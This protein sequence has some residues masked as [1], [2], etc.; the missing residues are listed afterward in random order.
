MDK[1]Q[2][3]MRR[4]LCWPEDV[5]GKHCQKRCLLT[6]L[7]LTHIQQNAVKIPVKYITPWLG[8]HQSQG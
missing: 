3:H 5:V 7:S 4:S 1:K 8:G 6:A 2:H